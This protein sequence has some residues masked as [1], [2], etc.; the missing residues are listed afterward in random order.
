MKL[1]KKK[2]FISYGD[3]E[4]NMELFNQA[5]GNN[6][7]ADGSNMATGM[8]ESYLLEDAIDDLDEI[9]DDEITD[10]E[11]ETISDDIDEIIDDTN[12]EITDDEIETENN[13]EIDDV[14]YEITKTVSFPILIEGFD[15]DNNP[16]KIEENDQEEL[17]SKY[18][19]S[20]KYNIEENMKFILSSLDIYNFAVDYE[21]F[22]E[23][24]NA[25]FNLYMQKEIPNDMIISKIK[26]Y[27]NVEEQLDTDYG[28]F[29]LS[30]VLDNKF[31]KM[32]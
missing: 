3:P 4:K 14:S 6:F 28:Y 30:P 19:E 26:R 11:E 29:T 20:V 32:N 5:L 2:Q 27:L 10:D 7:T 15:N 24:S 25:V 16:V 1:K 8:S 23:N 17:I 31:I 18:V 13:A 21:K 12:D 22:D 9:T